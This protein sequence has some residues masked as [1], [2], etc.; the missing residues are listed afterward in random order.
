MRAKSVIIVT[1]STYSS[2]ISGRTLDLL[3][4]NIFQLKKNPVVV[5]GP[6]GD[7]FLRESKLIEECEIVFDPNYQGGFFSGVKAGLHAIH[8]STAFVLP[9]METLPPDSIWVELEDYLLNPAED[10]TQCHLIRCVPDTNCR[11]E[12]IT[13]VVRLKKLDSQTSWNDDEQIKP[14]L[15]SQISR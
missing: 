2:L 12:L 14:R 15:I 11:V 7:A 10:L 13:D 6:D 1:S 9:L 5:L 8:G 4:Q 3:L